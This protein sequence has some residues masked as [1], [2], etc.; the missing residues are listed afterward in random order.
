M[1][2]VDVALLFVSEHLVGELNLLE[3]LLG[4]LVLVARLVRVMDLGKL[5]ICLLSLNLWAVSK[6]VRTGKRND[7][8]IN[9]VTLRMSFSL[10]VGDTFSNS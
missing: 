2:I 6:C 7:L 10:A 9:R 4:I 5:V 8:Y 1:T 3:L